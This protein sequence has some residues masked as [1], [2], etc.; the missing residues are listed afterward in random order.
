[1]SIS[2]KVNVPCHLTV[3]VPCPMS[4]QPQRSLVG[5]EIAHYTLYL[6][7]C[8]NMASGGG[9]GAP[10]CTLSSKVL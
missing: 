4:P 9:R 6:V 5:V 3:N 1:M 10:L 7:K 2:R 8:S